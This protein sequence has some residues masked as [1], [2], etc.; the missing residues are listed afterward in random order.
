MVQPKS[1]TASTQLRQAASS[2]REACPQ[3]EPS[4]IPFRNQNQS[5]C[6]RAEDHGNPLGW[7]V[8]L[9]PGQLCKVQLL[10]MQPGLAKDWRPGKPAARREACSNLIQNIFS[11][12]PCSFLLPYFLSSSTKKVES[13]KPL[14]KN[15]LMCFTVKAA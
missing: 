6:D 5:W 4:A 8:S 9:Q 13:L 15:P 10:L 3:Q 7:R 11:I 1:T 2:S 12:F 14:A